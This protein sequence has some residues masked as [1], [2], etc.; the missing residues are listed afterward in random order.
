MPKISRS[1]A[2]KAMKFGQL[3]EYNVSDIFL[4]K[5]SRN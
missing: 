4:Q 2:N 5:S 1:K 3:L